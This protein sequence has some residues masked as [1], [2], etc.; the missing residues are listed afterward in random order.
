MT[1]I[2]TRNFA[3]IATPVTLAHLR[4][5]WTRTLRTEPSWPTARRSRCFSPAMVMVMTTSSRC[6]SSAPRAGAGGCGW[7]IPERIFRPHR[8]V[9]SNVTKMPRAASISPTVQGLN[10]NR[11]YKP[12]RIPD[13]L[14][15]IAIA[16][17]RRG[18]RH[19]AQI[20]DY[21]GSAK[22]EAAQLDAAPCRVWRCTAFLD[23]T[24]LANSQG[25]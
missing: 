8:R 1:A 7:R 21:P 16:C 22:S 3:A 15:R 4:R 24:V 20:S 11:K 14:G 17:T 13:G 10:R 12:D 5:L 9:V 19:P 25:R 6:H 2:A 18:R 23:L